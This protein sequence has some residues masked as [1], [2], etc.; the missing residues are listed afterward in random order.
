MTVAQ[1]IEALKLMPQD[2]TVGY[3]TCIEVNRC[4]LWDAEDD[5]PAWVDLEQWS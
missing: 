3:D 4:R 1:L 5:R 2:A